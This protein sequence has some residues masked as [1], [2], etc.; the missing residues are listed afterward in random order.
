MNAYLTRDE[1]CPRTARLMQT[2]TRVHGDR[3]TCRDKRVHAAQ[4]KPWGRQ[5]RTTTGLRTIATQKWLL[6]FASMKHNN[7]IN[8]EI[9]YTY[10]PARRETLFTEHG[11]HN[12]DIVKDQLHEPVAKN[13]PFL[14]HNS[15]IF[16]TPSCTHTWQ[17]SSSRGRYPFE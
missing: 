17:S 10:V 4:R 3:T 15:K 16:A 5:R 12:V 6:N 9:V 14:R 1:P 13:Q 8:D 11:K 2:L 7:D